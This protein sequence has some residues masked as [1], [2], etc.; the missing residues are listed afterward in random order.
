PQWDEVGNCFHPLNELGDSEAA[1]REK[2]ETLLKQI[3][4]FPKG[5]QE[6]G[7]IHG[8]LHSENFLVDTASQSITV[9]DFDDCCTGWFLMDIAMNL[10]D[11][12]VVY[13]GEDKDAFAGRFMKSYLKGYLEEK[14]LDE[15]WIEQLPHFLKLLEIG[16]YTQVYAFAAREEPGSWVGKFIAGRKSRLE[17]DVPYVNV[18]FAQILKTISAGY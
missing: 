14:A 2:R 13:P 17:N 9:I 11:M 18:N 8:D 15:V 1:I 4:A 3:D 12:V 5:C 7:I 10:F 6:Y 16:V